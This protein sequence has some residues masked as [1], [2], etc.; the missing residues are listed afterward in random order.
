[1]I[2]NLLK[3][4]GKLLGPAG[5]GIDILGSLLASKKS[6]KA[7]GAGGG[8][9]DLSQL[10]AAGKTLQEQLR[11]VSALRQQ[12]NIGQNGTI[13]INIS[14]QPMPFSAPSGSPMANAMK[15]PFDALGP[16]KNMLGGLLPALN[17]ML[18]AL[19]GGSGAAG[20]GEASGSAPSASP[21]ASTTS[22]PAA[23]ASEAG[24][25][26]GSGS[27]TPIGGDSKGWGAIDSMMA[28]AEKLA[29]SKNPSDQLRAQQLMQQAQQMFQTISKLLQQLSEMFRTAIGNIK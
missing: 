29:K 28:E 10:Q 8:S 25:A 5:I 9:I 21:A 26:S 19:S 11:Q 13:T 24:S 27:S 16:L 12:M 20:T 22:A 1:M 4:A 15:N 14:A 17:K 3:T 7:E 23:S 2:G 6:S 18:Q